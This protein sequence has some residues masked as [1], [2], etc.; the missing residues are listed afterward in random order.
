FEQAG[1]RES[2]GRLNAVF[3]EILDR[4]GPSSRLGTRAKIL[5]VSQV[6]VH[7]P[8]IVLVV[9]KPDLFKGGYERYI[10]NRLHEEL[11]YSEVPIRLVFSQR[12]RLELSELKAGRNRA[13]DS[14]AED[15]GSLEGFDPA[16][17]PDEGDDR[18]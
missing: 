18:I 2:T 6:A 4:R 12:R 10:L 7:P 17:L 3:K 15:V 5:Y 14:D 9:N 11:P 8:T 1:H 13:G 16:D